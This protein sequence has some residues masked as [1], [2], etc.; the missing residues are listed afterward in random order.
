MSGLG[1]EAREAAQHPKGTGQCPTRKTC[2]VPNVSSVRLGHPTPAP[3][4]RTLRPV[5]D[6]F[7]PFADCCSFLQTR[8]TF[9]ILG[10]AT[11][12][13]GCPRA[14]HLHPP[15]VSLH[16]AH[17]TRARC[18]QAPRTAA[19]HLA[20]GCPC[21]QP[22]KLPLEHSSSGYLPQRPSLCVNGGVS[23]TRRNYEEKCVYVDTWGF[24]WEQAGMGG[25]HFWARRVVHESRE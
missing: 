22:G 24:L 16:H 18:S 12:D 6:W 21:P 4:R 13:S 17:P 10:M 25:G 5:V 19:L 9:W 11:G 1:G 3:P 20:T 23:Y 15:I 7:R 14:L 8:G 2:P